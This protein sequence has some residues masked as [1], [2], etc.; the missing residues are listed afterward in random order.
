[1]EVRHKED[2]SSEIVI[3]ILVANGL[4]FVLKHIIVGVEVI[5][6]L[7]VEVAN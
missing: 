7:F 5:I 2:S 6:S 3:T 1:V 4:Q